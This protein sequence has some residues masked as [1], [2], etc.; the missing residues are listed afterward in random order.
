MQRGL[1]IDSEFQAAWMFG[2]AKCV[3]ADGQS[4]KLARAESGRM[5]AVNESMDD[6]TQGFFGRRCLGDASA[7][8]L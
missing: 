7:L 3:S 1:E 5:K 8:V 4:F 6:S 2:P